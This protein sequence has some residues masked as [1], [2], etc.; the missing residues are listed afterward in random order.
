MPRE[1]PKRCPLGAKAQDSV[2]S[3]G[4]LDSLTPPT[5]TSGNP[6][7]CAG[8]VALNAAQ[9]FRGKHAG[10]VVGLHS[11]PS[12]LATREGSAG[13]WQTPQTMAP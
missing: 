11:A 13:G 9:Q 8:D 4:V 7:E 3:H 6:Q 5:L 1:L 10:G 12:Q 2:I